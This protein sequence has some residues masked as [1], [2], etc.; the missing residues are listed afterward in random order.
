MWEK[1]LL[2]TSRPS[3]VIDK[4]A[5]KILNAAQ[6]SKFKFVA[7]LHFMSRNFSMWNTEPTMLDPYGNSQ[8]RSDE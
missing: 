2:H 4:L 3:H 1:I 5:E 7:T 8:D 6:S